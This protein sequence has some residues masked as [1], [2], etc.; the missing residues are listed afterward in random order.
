MCCAE[1]GGVRILLRKKHL[2]F[3]TVQLLIYLV[4]SIAFLGIVT[5]CLNVVITHFF[6]T[7]QRL[8][9]D[10]DLMMAIDFL[11]YDFWYKS[12]STAQVNASALSFKEKVDGKEKFVWYR[13][14]VESGNYVLKRIANDGVN[15]IYISKEPVSFYEDDGIWGVKIGTLC[16]D[17]L[18][19]TPSSV[20]E[21]LGLKPGQLPPFLTPKYV[22][23]ISE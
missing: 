2:S 20:R 19:A 21:A 14:D 16:F 9:E 18:N 17:M 15:V 7:T 8:E 5:L 11:R 22:G 4:V 1:C 3:I 12:I 23:C 13:V 6:Q 10:L